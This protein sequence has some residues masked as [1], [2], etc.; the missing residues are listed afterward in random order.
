M[1]LH[2]FALTVFNCLWICLNKKI[3]S[4]NLYLI[5]LPLTLLFT[6]MQA[7]EMMFFRRVSSKT[8][9]PL[10]RSRLFGSN[11]G[12]DFSK[13]IQ[14]LNKVSFHVLVWSLNFFFLYSSNIK[15][16]TLGRIV[17]KVEIDNIWKFWI[18]K[19]KWYYD[20]LSKA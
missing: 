13:A 15:I 17:N 7:L 6:A 18:L 10:Q 9:R 20:L 19:N 11:S 16:N 1:L 2:N 8:L 14:E 3:E 4:I 12:Y 5:F